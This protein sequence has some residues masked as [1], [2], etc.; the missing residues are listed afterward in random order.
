[1]YL[2]R[3]V[4]SGSEINRLLKLDA[5]QARY[6]KDGYWYD[7]LH[8][9]PGILIDRDGY[10]RF[11]TREEYE[12]SPDLR[13]PD[14]NRIDGRPGTLSVPRKI[15]SLA[16]YVR[17]SR[18]SSLHEALPQSAAA[19]L[20]PNKTYIANLGLKNIHWPICR[21]ESVL[22]LET[23]RTL[24]DFWLQRDRR[25]WIDWASKNERMINGQLAI[26][27]VASRWFNLITIFHDTLND[28]WLH[29]AGDYLY[30]ALSEPGAISVEALQDPRGRDREFILLKRQTFKW[31]DRARDGRRL[32]WKSIH[33]K[34][35]DFLR[36]EATYQEVQNDRGYRDYALA[37]LEGPP[38]EEF[39]TRPD[40]RARQGIR[41]SGRTLSSLEKTIIN[42]MLNI[43]GTVARADGRLIETVAKIKKIV[44]NEE[45]FKRFLEHLYRQQEGL[46][47]LTGLKM[48]LLDDEGEDDFR[49]S[50]DRVDSAGDY[51]TSNVQLVC[52]FANFWKSASDN[53]RFKQLIQVIRES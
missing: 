4:L 11:E 43:K 44:G 2:R 18:I 51:T 22:T 39:H 29:R 30:W 24:Y 8:S 16:G 23:S 36:T 21:S 1:M 34:A 13:H 46:C 12:Q 14:G 17:D 6:H 20:N 25:G 49:L 52:R 7:Q 37:L 35:H 50:V 5:A 26:A 42:A 41:S 15:S 27:P 28:V 10:L 32:L 47:A 31:A 33:H 45:D 3:N 53:A 19:A 40:W 48:L 9:F 38:L